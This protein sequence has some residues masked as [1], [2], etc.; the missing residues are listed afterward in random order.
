MIRVDIKNDDA[1][2]YYDVLE[3]LKKNNKIPG[4]SEY[5]VHNICQ[6]F[7]DD[8]DPTVTKL[9]AYLDKYLKG[10]S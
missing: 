3:S 5:V 9:M 10:F 6:L 8:T 1:T 4:L 2:K 7:K